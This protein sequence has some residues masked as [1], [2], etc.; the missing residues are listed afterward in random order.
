[1]S[2][3]SLKAAQFKSTIIVISIYGFL[4]L[5][6]ILAFFFY[7]PA[8]ELLADT[9]PLFSILFIV[10]ACIVSALLTWNILAAVPTAVALN[11]PLASCPDGWTLQPGISTDPLRSVSCQAPPGVTFTSDAAHVTSCRGS[12][13]SAMATATES[14]TKGE[15]C[16]CS[17]LYPTL[18]IS[19][20]SVTDPYNVRCDYVDMCNVPWGDISAACD[21]RVSEAN[22]KNKT[23]TS[24][25]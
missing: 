14:P 24:S 18:M 23:L 17:A 2:A 5:S 13:G 1:M 10:G 20:E 8:S 7:R 25:Y 6:M 11:V 9:F 12:S 3:A 15:N 4:V 19:K 22:T 21:R 16:S